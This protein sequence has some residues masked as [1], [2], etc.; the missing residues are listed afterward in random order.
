MQHPGNELGV[1]L[2]FDGDCRFCSSSVRLFQRIS[3]NRVPTKPYQLADLDT[4][5]LTKEQCAQ[6]VQFVSG[7]GVS[8]GHL[9]IADA[10][11]ASKTIWVL[12]GVIMKLPVITSIAY[13]IYSWVSKNRHKLP[14]GTPACSV[15]G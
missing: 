12:A 1:M 4:L 10:L 13:L 2:V 5:N 11:I 6:A 3:K 14:G 15:N 8:A 9:A 7:K